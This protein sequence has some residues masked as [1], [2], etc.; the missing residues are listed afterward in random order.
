M[1]DIPKLMIEKIGKL[2]GRI[3]AALDYYGANHTLKRIKEI[4]EFNDADFILTYFQ[5]FLQILTECYRKNKKPHEFPATGGSATWHVAA[6]GPSPL[7]IAS[8]PD[9]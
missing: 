3:Q 1:N 8:G 6:R 4:K 7:L 9:L 5:Q 2:E